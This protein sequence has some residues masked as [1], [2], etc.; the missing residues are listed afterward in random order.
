VIELAVASDCRAQASSGGCQSETSLSPLPYRNYEVTVVRG[1]LIVSES[2][3]PVESALISSVMKTGRNVMI[4]FPGSYTLPTGSANPSS[5]SSDR[6]LGAVSDDADVRKECS[7]THFCKGGLVTSHA[8]SG[9][10]ETVIG[11]DI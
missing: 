8:R 10:R 2:E 6:R 5:L 3:S 4:S 9:G 7:G 11:N 1:F